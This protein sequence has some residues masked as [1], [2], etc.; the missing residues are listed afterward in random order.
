VTG[1]SGLVGSAIESNFKPSSEYVNL[2]HVEDIIRYITRNKIDSIIHCAAKVGGIKANSDHLGEFFYKN[3]IMNANLLHAAHEAGVKKVVSFMSTCVFPDDV[4]YPLT[5][6]QI[7]MGEP[8]PSNYSYAY[9]KR[10]LEVQSRA[11]RDQYGSNFVTVI[12]CNIYG[13]NDN[14]NL[15]SG[16]V[17]PSLIHKCYLAKQNNTDFEIW[18]TGQAYRE[19]IYSKD[20]AYIAQWVLEN[21]DEY[22]PLIISPDEEISIA[23]IAQEIAWRMEFEGNIVYNGMR[24]GQLKKPSNNMTLK[25]M[26]PDYTFVPIEVGLRRTIEW[27]I[28]NYEKAR[29]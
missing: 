12:P 22:E 26:L 20:V 14:F 11:Y 15:D 27:F 7:H 29:K 2:M 21:Y 10:M 1:G 3:V 4:E 6:C 13:P 8:H 19:F 9:A 25:H 28:E 5:P 16:H 23:T 18:G 24:D 17:I